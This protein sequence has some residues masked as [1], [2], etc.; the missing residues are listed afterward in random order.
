MCIIYVAY[1]ISIHP[2]DAFLHQIS[3]ANTILH[4]LHNFCIA[5]CAQVINMHTHADPP[6]DRYGSELAAY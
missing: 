4:K 2:D 6:F 3:H 1:K 5:S